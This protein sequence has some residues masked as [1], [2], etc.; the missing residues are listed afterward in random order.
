[1][2]QRQID[3]GVRDR[4]VKYREVLGRARRER[5]GG[6]GHPPLSPT[7]VSGEDGTSAVVVILA[8]GMPSRFGSFR[9]GRARGRLKVV[10]STWVLSIDVIVT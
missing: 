7:E 5:R 1:L 6:S 2:A 3:K 4:V 10:E 8:I 9:R